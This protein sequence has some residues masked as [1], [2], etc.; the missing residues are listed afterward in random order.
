MT[1]SDAPIG[2]E[3]GSGL[4]VRSY[5]LTGGRTRG[6]ADLPV[7]APIQVTP[8]GRASIPALALEPR[9]VIPPRLGTLSGAQ[10]SAPPPPPP[11]GV[12]G[13]VRR[14]VPAGLPPA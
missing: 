13:P 14:T 11:P 10:D 8:R 7:E 3:G 1:T 4:R 6:G 12:P 2:S 5:V 9:D